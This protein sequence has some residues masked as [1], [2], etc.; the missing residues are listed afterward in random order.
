MP[1]PRGTIYD[2]NGVPLVANQGRFTVAIDLASLQSDFR[3]EF[4]RIR[5]NYRDTGDHDLPTAD[6][7]E[8]IARTSVV[9]RYLDQGR[10]PSCAGRIAWIRRR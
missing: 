4:I 6:D 10:M 8:Q 1:G 9:Q 5:T 7:M 2:R 3:R